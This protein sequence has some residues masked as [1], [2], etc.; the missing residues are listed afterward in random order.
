MAKGEDTRH[1]PNRKVGRGIFQQGAE[2]AMTGQLPLIPSGISSSDENTW[3]EGY[4][5]GEHLLGVPDTERNVTP[6]GQ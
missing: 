6:R 4:D 5:Y 3:M 1:H 2:S